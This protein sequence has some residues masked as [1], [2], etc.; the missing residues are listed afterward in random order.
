[1]GSG[2]EEIRDEIAATRAE[3]AADVDRLADRTVPSRIVQRRTSRMRRKIDSVRARVM[4]TPVHAAH[5]ARHQAGQVAGAVRDTASDVAGTVRDTASETAGT[6]RDTAS[7]AAGTVKHGAQ[8]AAGAVREAPDQ[9]MRSTQGNPLAA[10]LIAFGAGLLAAAL[11]PGTETEQQA[12]QQLREQ[13][14]DVIEPVKTAVQESAQR[15][16]QD[17]KGAAQEA[18][19]QVRETATEA[20][21]ATGEHARDQAQQVADPN[22]SPFDR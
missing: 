16:G 11:I 10:G 19:Q 4:G 15:L 6:V 18:V 22:R 7:E 14:G 9:A 17:A 12:A 3:L 21:R 13:A 20:A 8:Q 1:M 5:Q 2:P